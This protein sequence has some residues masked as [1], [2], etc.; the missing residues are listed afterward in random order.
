MPS[1]TE[2]PT[3]PGSA[4]SGYSVGWSYLATMMSGLIVWGGVGLWVDVMLDLRWLFL[5]IGILVG[6]G[7][8]I[9]LAQRRYG[10]GWKA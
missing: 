6:I 3:R 7:G 10:G 9:Y 5:P 4:W 1:P 8:G 2:R